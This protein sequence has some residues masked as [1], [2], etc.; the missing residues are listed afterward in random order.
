ME[1]LTLFVLFVQGTYNIS[2]GF[3][4]GR[5]LSN[6]FKYEEEW[7]KKHPAG[8]ERER[9]GEWILQFHIFCANHGIYKIF[10]VLSD[11]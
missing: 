5:I 11:V 3:C 1:K 10:T 4:R 7:Q 6:L 2:E 9:G 8:S